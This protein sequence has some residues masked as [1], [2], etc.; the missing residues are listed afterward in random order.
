M[1]A[2]DHLARAGAAAHETAAKLPAAR[3]AAADAIR[4][5]HHGQSWLGRELDRFGNWLADHLGFGLSL[6][7]GG[8]SILGLLTYLVLAAI[9]GAAVWL[10][11][12]WVRRAS[13]PQLPS[14]QRTRAESGDGDPPFDEAKVRALGMARS[15]PRE[16][17]RVLYVALLRELGRRHGWKPPPGRSNW[18]FVRRLGLGS[19]PGAALAECTRLFEGRVYGAVPAAPGDVLR[20]AELSD[21]VLA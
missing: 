10:I 11:V 17:V 18:A 4:T 9:I 15:D 13:R 21:T 7:S 2:A 5:P 8:S 6:G 20:I 19:A 3:R 12:R 1:A 16:A 14:F